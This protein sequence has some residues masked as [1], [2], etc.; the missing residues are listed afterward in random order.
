MR[1]PPTG[2]PPQG[3]GKT[4]LFYG[5]QGGQGGGTIFF[6][7]P[8]GGKN[9]CIQKPFPRLLF[10][11]LERPSGWFKALLVRGKKKKQ[12]RKK[13]FFLGFFWFK[14]LPMGGGLFFLA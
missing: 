8:N 11:D 6:G 9:P 3:G 2:G 10:G 4:F 7:G 12:K 14:F 1:G 5:G 13:G